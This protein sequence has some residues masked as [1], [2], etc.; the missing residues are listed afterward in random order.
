MAVI[1]RNVTREEIHALP[2]VSVRHKD[3]NGEYSWND[4]KLRG[5]D[6]LPSGELVV[7]SGYKNREKWIEAKEKLVKALEKSAKGDKGK[8]VLPTSRPQ[9]STRFVLLLTEAEHSELLGRAI[10]ADMSMS[11]Y[12]RRKLFKGE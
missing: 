2:W 7:F 6:T 12:A 3:S 8:T 10:E 5:F 11:V 4:D 1:K 9:R